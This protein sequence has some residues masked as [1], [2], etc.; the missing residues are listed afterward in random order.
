MHHMHQ[1]APTTRADF[2][3]PLC[4]FPSQ[5][6]DSDCDS[7]LIDVRKIFAPFANEADIELTFR[8]LAVRAPYSRARLMR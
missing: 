1:A 6:N 5:S 3:D 7:F 4:D 8:I 2:N